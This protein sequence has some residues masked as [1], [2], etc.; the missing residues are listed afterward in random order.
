[1]DPELKQLRN[2]NNIYFKGDRLF[3][4]EGYMVMQGQK[5]TKSKNHERFCC[6]TNGF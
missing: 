2:V 5:G 1:M 6:G 3:Q 4:M